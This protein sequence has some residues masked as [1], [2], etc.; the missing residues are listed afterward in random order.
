MDC[1]GYERQ[2]LPT[3]AKTLDIKPLLPR[4]SCEI[5]LCILPTTALF[6]SEDEH[7]YFLLFRDEVALDLSGPL[8]TKTWNYII[9]QASAHSAV[10]RDLIVSIAALSKSKTSLELSSSH[11]SFAIR[12]YGKALNNL[13]QVIAESND[14]A[15][16]I[17]LI[18]S[19][20]IFCFENIHGDYEQ[21]VVQLRS[22]LIM[23]RN[24]LSTIRRPYSCLKT[25]CSIPGLEDDLLNTFIRLDSTIMSRAGDS[26][27]SRASVL[28]M[29][30]IGEDFRMPSTFK[31]ITESKHYIEHVQF[32]AMPYLAHL[33][34]VFM[35][36][37]Q[38][39]YVPPRSAYDEL[40]MHMHQW[41]RAFQPLL[42]DAN[43]RG[44]VEFIAAA[45][46]R[47]LVL[48]TDIS[49]QRIFFGAGGAS[50][51]D[52]FVPEGRE[53]VELTR[54]VVENKCFKKTFVVDCGIVPSLFVAF[55]ICRNKSIRE[56]AVR[57]LELAGD[58]MEVT[59]N[60]AAVAQMGR[61]LL[62]AEDELHTIQLESPP[63]V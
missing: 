17:S 52:L 5:P 39:R 45:T 54:K 55:L 2:P 3:K 37:D 18:A 56:E 34:D 25:I 32:K 57:V 9:L 14:H 4:A 36:G 20:L 43:R 8:P 10:L 35:Y 59:W 13:R 29:E 40:S 11:R 49:A 63:S 21:A 53:I 6:G 33:A 27:D 26:T 41:R 46:Q 7:R 28:Q 48:A 42:D 12:Q 19:L 61:E 58:R 1:D 38:F 31:D 15:V 51:P 30:Y 23:M 24:R 62:R 22:A 60:A 47:V 16:R 50:N 44:G